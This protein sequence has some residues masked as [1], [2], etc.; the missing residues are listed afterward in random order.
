M[1]LTRGKPDPVQ[2]NPGHVAWGWIGAAFVLT[3]SALVWSI[4]AEF[5]Y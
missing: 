1:T 5:L 2:P 4:V 3:F